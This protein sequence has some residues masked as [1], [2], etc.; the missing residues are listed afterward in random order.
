MLLTP[1]NFQGMLKEIYDTII[2]QCRGLIADINDD[3]L[4]TQVSA[5]GVNAVTGNNSAVTVNFPLSTASN[6]LTSGFTKLI[7]DARNNEFNLADAMIVGSGLIDNY[8]IQHLAN[9]KSTDQS[10]QLS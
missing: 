4:T 6:P 3:L 10:G 8:M 2:E 7:S 9:A 5:F 1:D